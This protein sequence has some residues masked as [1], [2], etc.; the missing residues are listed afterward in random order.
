MMVL[1][2]GPLSPAWCSLF[3]WASR[4]WLKGFCRDGPT[5]G[6]DLTYKAVKKRTCVSQLT[7]YL[8]E[9]GAVIPDELS[10]C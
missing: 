8:T 10:N 2:A 6:T 3:L 9:A 4:Y 7:C 5:L 1:T